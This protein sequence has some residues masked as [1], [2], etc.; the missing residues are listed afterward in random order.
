MR[1]V[2]LG[3][4]PHREESGLIMFGTWRASHKYLPCA[5]KS[6]H[7]AANDDGLVEVCVKV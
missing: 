6:E 3:L 5:L 1:G 7:A 4:G 2:Q